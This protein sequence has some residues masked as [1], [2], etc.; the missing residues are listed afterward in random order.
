VVNDLYVS[1]AG[2]FAATEQGLFCSQDEGRTWSSLRF[3]AVELPTQSVRVSRD[4]ETL[5]IAS[6][7]GMLFSDDGGR[8]W[9]WHDLPLESGGALK[10]EWTDATTLVAEARTGLYISR[11]GGTKWNKAGVGLPGARVEELLLRP[12]MWLVSMQSAGQSGGLY[13]SMDEGLSW[14][15]I[16][17]KSVDESIGTGTEFPVLAAAD[18]AE[19][20]FAGSASD[21]LYMLELNRVLNAG[22][23]RTAQTQVAGRGGH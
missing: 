11:D 23:S 10:L 1:E 20:I 17:S 19:R 21:G 7:N 3:S 18:T 15:R 22:A 5:R 12:G 2:W 16:K 4:G 9:S 13:A 6:S 14:S 8:S